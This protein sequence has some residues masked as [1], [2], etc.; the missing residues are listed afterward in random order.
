MFPPGIPLSKRIFDLLGSTISMLLFAPVFLILSLC[1]RIS[2]GS[3]IIFRQKRP[4]YQSRPFWIY[5][6]RTMTDECD[7]DG[8]LLPDAQRI[9]SLG[10]F[11]RSSSLDELPELYNIFRGEM[12]FIGP[13]PLLMEYLSRYSSEQIRRHNALPGISGWAQIHGRN[14]LTWEDKFRYDVWYVDNW[15]F[16][17]DIKIL[18]LTIGKV[19]SR[20]GINQPGHA[21]SEEF[22]G[23]NSNSQGYN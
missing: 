3:P 7:E 18:V 10:Q 5:K 8:N 15:S 12:S 21:T 19:L 14:L 11:L 1:I 20:E 17:L 6:F 2:F 9:T 23:E 16:L 4:G 13:R 22:L